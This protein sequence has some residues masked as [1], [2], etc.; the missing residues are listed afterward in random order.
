MGCC[1]SRKGQEEA[2]PSFSLDHSGLTKNTLSSIETLIEVL[3]PQSSTLDHL[4]HLE[5]L[6]LYFTKVHSLITKELMEPLKLHGNSIQGKNWAK[7][8]DVKQKID[9]FV[10]DFRD[11]MAKDSVRSPED[12]RESCLKNL[13]D[14]HVKMNEFA[15]D[16]QEVVKQ[17]L[18]V[19]FPDYTEG[20]QGISLTH[21]FSGY[22]RILSKL[23]T[24]EADLKEKTEGFKSLVAAEFWAKNFS[25]KEIADLEEFETKFSLMTAQMHKV[26]LYVEDLKKVRE[27]L[28]GENGVE[29]NKFDDFVWKIW[30]IGFRRKEFLAR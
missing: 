23:K 30:N 8:R 16:L 26:N 9:R 1:Q 27:K 28:G 29:R 14:F 25:G 10:M 19:F 17:G 3:Q 21:F 18:T 20:A 12:H 11:L 2:L 7:L 22:D 13:E 4:P 6:V 15:A 24:V 5:A